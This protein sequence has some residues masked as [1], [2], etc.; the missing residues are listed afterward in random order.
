MLHSAVKTITTTFIS[1]LDLCEIGLGELLRWVVW[2]K[3]F[4]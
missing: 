2:L 1:S 4:L 3:D